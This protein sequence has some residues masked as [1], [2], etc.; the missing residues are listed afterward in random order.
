MNQ[1]S[2]WFKAGGTQKHITLPIF[3]LVGYIYKSELVMEK[4]ESYM[5]IA[6]YLTN[7]I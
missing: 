2:I 4:L 6:M 1:K 3:G 7:E 5:S